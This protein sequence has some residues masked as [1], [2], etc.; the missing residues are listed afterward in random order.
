MS[1][2]YGSAFHC[3]MGQ[4]GF[5]LGG[6][7][8]GRVPARWVAH[9]RRVRDMSAHIEALTLPVHQPIVAKLTG[10]KDR[11]LLLRRQG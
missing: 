3:G 9:L 6:D 10:R 7:A 8:R 2:A 1:L 11:P 5:N 4:K